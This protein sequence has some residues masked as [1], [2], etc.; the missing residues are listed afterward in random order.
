MMFKF[1]WNV[2]KTLEFICSRK[3][4]IEITKTIIKQLQQLEG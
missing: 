3:T 1:R 2:H 4:D